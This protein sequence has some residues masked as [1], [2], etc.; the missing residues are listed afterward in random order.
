MIKYLQHCGMS[1]HSACIFISYYLAF[2]ITQTVLL[3]YIIYG[4]QLWNIFFE[5]ISHNVDNTICVT[6]ELPWGLS[7]SQLLSVL[8]FVFFLCLLFTHQLYQLFQALSFSLQILWRRQ[9]TPEKRAPRKKKLKYDRKNQKNSPSY[10]RYQT[11]IRN[12]TPSSNFGDDPNANLAEPSSQPVIQI[13]S[14]DLMSI[15]PNT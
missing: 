1:F 5:C 3:V 13:H 6:F 12:S 11:Q 9:M 14:G 7:L 2:S 15:L 8:L 4:T 10:Q